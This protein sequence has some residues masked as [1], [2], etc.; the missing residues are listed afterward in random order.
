MSFNWGNATDTPVSA[1]F[2]GDGSTDIAVFRD[3]TWYIIES[4]TGDARIVS[5]GAQGDLPVA[6][7]YDGDGTSDI[8]VWRP[9][10]GN[11]YIQ[12]SATS[13]QRVLAP[14]ANFGI[15]WGQNGDVPVPFAYVPEQ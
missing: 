4:L 10:N 12:E 7:D 8:A 2:D 11:W 13:L 15:H 6:A 1:D 5:W 9:S 14:D 3:G